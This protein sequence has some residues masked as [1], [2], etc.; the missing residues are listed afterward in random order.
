MKKQEGGEI[1]IG[2]L[3]FLLIAS[4]FS[5]YKFGENITCDKNE[6]IEYE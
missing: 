3:D 4:L 1:V 2:I 5:M 6:E